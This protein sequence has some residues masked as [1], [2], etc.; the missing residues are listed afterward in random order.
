MSTSVPAQS[1]QLRQLRIMV[2]AM[3]AVP[4]VVLVAMWFVLSDTV[5]DPTPWS[6]VIGVLALAVVGELVLRSIGYRTVVLAR[7]LTKKEAMSQ[8]RLSYQATLFRRMMIAELPMIVSLTLA[9]TIPGGFYLVLFGSAATL[10]LLVLHVWPSE[11]SVERTRASLELG[12]NRSYLRE[13][14]GLPPIPR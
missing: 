11:R 9:F 5:T 8:S 13:A 2:G 12:G 6:F 3:L 1:G 7:G 10:N 4:V 14:L